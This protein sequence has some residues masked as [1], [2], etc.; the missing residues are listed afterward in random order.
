[1]N[2]QPIF[3]PIESCPSRGITGADNLKIHDRLRNRWKCRDCGKTFSGNCGTL[4]YG[5]KHESQL[6]VWVV[7]LLAYGCPLQAIVRT[8]GLDE[9]TVAAWQKKAGEHCRQ[10]HEHLIVGQP[11]DLK[12]V[13]ADEIRAKR[14]GK[15]ALWMA[16]ALCVPTR[17]WLGG[18]VSPSRNKELIWR[19][20]KMI[21]SQALERPL[22]LATDGLASYVS[23]FKRAFTSAIPRLSGRGR[24][25]L[26]AWTCVVIGRVIK[27]YEKLRCKGVEER[28]LAQGSWEAFAVLSLPGQI[29]NTAYIERL[30]A[31]FRQRLCGLVRR[32]RCLPSKEAV[33]STSMYLIGTVYNFCTPHHSLTAEQSQ[34]RGESYRT[35]AMADGIADRVWSVSDLLCRTIAPPPYIPPKPKSNRGRPKGSKNKPKPPKEPIQ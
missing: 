29:L 33:L 19:L 3:C 30:N 4:F 7:S 31:T 27:S 17:L 15:S 2:P 9:R 11:R 1:V 25:K 13:Q 10:V 35:P 23:C 16:M 34:G 18:V 12:Q 6:V 22:L 24:P 14:Q 32:G 21:R 20:V 28:R 8:F 26:R 5:L